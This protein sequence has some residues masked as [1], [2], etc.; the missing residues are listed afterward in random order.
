MFGF[1]VFAIVI[2]AL[3]ILILFASVKTVSQGYNWTF[4]RFGKYTRTLQP[5][6]T[7]IAPSSTASAAR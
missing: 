3:A 2:V 1:D 6:L 7:L 5:G 4:E